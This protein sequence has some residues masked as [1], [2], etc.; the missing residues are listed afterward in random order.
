MPLSSLHID[1]H[2]LLARIYGH[3]CIFKLR[4]IKMHIIY[5]IYIS[6]R[7]NSTFEG[8]E[9][10]ELTS[11]MNVKANYLLGQC[12]IKVYPYNLRCD[13]ERTRLNNDFFYQVKKVRTV[14]K[15]QVWDYRQHT[16]C[17]IPT[18]EYMYQWDQSPCYTK[19]SIH[20]LIVHC[21]SIY[22]PEILKNLT[23]DELTDS[24]KELQSEEV[25]K[26]GN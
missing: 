15:T 18:E 26:N 25:G 10:K 21:I 23:G 5:L 8:N 22:L 4:T 1:P 19:L 3:K 6:Y 20:Q 9:V 7:E 17:L 2:H 24:H 11:G 13:H 16:D 12:I 14:L